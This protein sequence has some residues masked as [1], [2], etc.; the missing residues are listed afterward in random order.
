MLN[1]KTEDELADAIATADGPLS[2]RGGATRGFE[3]E[4]T[5]LSTSEMSGI[6]L[7]EPGALTIVAKAGT[8]VAEIDA[9]LAAENQT[10]AFEPM[11]H[12]SLLG[13]DGVP[14]IGGVVATNT[15]GPR[16]VLAGACRDFLLGVRFV[17]GTG[18]VIKNGGRVMK[19][20]TGYDLARLTCGAHGTLGV[21]TEV[22]LKVL[23]STEGI[24]TLV[25]SGL[26]WATSASVFASAMSSPFEV[27]GAARLP[28][29]AYLPDDSAVMI[30]LT[31]FE[32]SVKY[33]TSEL[34]KRLAPIAGGSPDQIETNLGRN[35]EV[36]KGI[37]DVHAFAG[38]DKDIWRISL[39]LSDLSQL[40]AIGT[41]D[42][43][44]LDWA[45]GRAWAS[46]APGTDV[47]AALGSFEGH[48]TLVRGRA[49]VP[50]F[51]PEAAPLAQMATALRAKY[52]PKGILNPGLMG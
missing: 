7:Y 8:P 21:L 13:T 10:L 5:P 42:D 6:T 27:S 25:Y 33:R 41:E 17:D 15:S 31:G 16:R 39:K 11:D 24:A 23:P 28:K 32:E 45:G 37:R 26:D 14:T 19:N 48:A 3:P 9:A 35:T 52:D 22:S 34:E 43:F 51:H 29:G 18:T 38:S 46:V 47:R 50:K 44:L 20:V 4:G 30:R 40:S 36:W 12:R 2:I 1:P 49:A